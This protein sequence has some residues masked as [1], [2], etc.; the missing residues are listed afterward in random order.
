M[1]LADCRI[2]AGFTAP[3]LSITKVAAPPRVVVGDRVEYTIEVTNGGPADASQVAVVDRQ[4]DGNVRILSATASQGRCRVTSETRQGVACLLGKIAPGDRVTVVVAGRALAHGTVRNRATVVSLPVDRDP[5][6]NQVVARVIVGSSSV[7][8]TGGSRRTRVDACRG[9]CRRRLRARRCGTCA[10][11]RL[12][13][14]D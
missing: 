4:L 9:R 5:A 2:T 7:L 12:L 14:H 13:V 11:S 6:N 10:G 1:A 8:G 3:D